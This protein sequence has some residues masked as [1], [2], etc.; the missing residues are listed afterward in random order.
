MNP[1]R[2]TFS[3]AIVLLAPLA[4]LAGAKPKANTGKAYRVYAGTY[5]TK[6]PSKGIYQFRFDPASG[7]MSA[8]E[9]AAETGDPSWVVIHP[10]G[11]YL[12]AA[13]EAGKASAISAFAI[14]AKTGKLTLLN[15]LPALGEDPCYLSFDRTGKYLFTANYSSGN[16]AVFPI[17]PDGKLGEHTALVQNKGALGPNKERQEG[18]HAH[19][20]EPSLDNHFLLVADLGL[21]AILIYRFDSTK[22]ALTPNKP[23]FIRPL[24]AGAGPRHATF[25]PDGSYFYALSEINSTVT[26]FVYASGPGVLGYIRVAPMLPANFDGRNEAAEIEIHPSG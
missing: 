19:W 2:R 20:V 24:D 8:A 12:Y 5:T 4:F 15:Q 13:N 16:V 6:T 26:T 11:R 10:N 3:A 21:D 1:L 9:L 7:K 14:D 23:I 18:P 25:S 22:G 17:L